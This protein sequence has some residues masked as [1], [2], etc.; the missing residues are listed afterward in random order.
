MSKENLQIVERLYEA[1]TR[2][3]FGVVPE[4]MDPEIEYVNPDYA[5]EPGIRRGYDGF[6]I[7]SEALT[8]VYGGFEVTDPELEDLGGRVL[9]KA[10]VRTRSSGNAVPIEAE[11]GYVFD[12]RDGRVTRFAWFNKYADALEYSRR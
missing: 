12:I 3:G 9:V 1:W 7:A 6:A 5:V 8:S 11:R 2:D 10:R 4:L